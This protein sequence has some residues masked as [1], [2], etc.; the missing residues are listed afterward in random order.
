MALRRGWSRRSTPPACGTLILPVGMLMTH[1]TLYAALLAPLL[2]SGLLFLPRGEPHPVPSAASE[3]PPSRAEGA[4]Q[5]AAAHERYSP[6]F[7]HMRFATTAW[8]YDTGNQA[9][10]EHL[11]R[12]YDLLLAPLAVEQIHSLNPTGENL[13][14]TLLW[15]MHQP[16]ENADWYNEM[17]AW[18]AD[19]MR[20]LRDYR[21]EDAFLHTAQPRT[22][23][24]RMLTP[25]PN[26]DHYFQT[27]RWI[28]NPA[29]PGYRAYTIDRFND[30]LAHAPLTSIF[31]DEHYHPQIHWMRG[32][33]E[34]PTEAAFRAAMIDFYRT[35]RAGIG[36]HMIM[37]NTAQSHAWMFGEHG[38][39]LWALDMV[40]EAGGLHMEQMVNPVL[41][42]EW[43][44]L[45]W[46]QWQTTGAVIKP[47][48][49]VNREEYDAGHIHGPGPWTRGNHAT[50]GDRG[51]M[52]E[53]TVVYLTMPAE[54]AERWYFSPAPNLT[55]QQ[56]WYPPYERDIGK[57]VA[58]RYAI[59]EGTDP[60]GQTAMVWAREFTNALVLNRP[61][62]HDA[63]WFDDETA[64]P[65][66]LPPGPWYRVLD[67]N[68]LEATPSTS[69]SLRLAEGAIFVRG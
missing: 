64:M 49:N 4:P 26:D 46:E 29:D 23:A 15:H 65:V 32:S 30:L 67:D 14:Y 25:L 31:V 47:T 54:G 10:I 9:E 20:N 59:F 7:P 40:R 55:F 43:N 39:D 45:V 53:I 66:D 16:Q 56:S 61:R 38:E 24:T 22:E 69:I 27:P 21:F 57:P 36:G 48:A 35:V 63:G 52:W 2:L 50:P 34:L 19:R 41:P 42:Y 44:L 3:P 6:H 33:V 68:T 12:H 11:A 37:L 18:Y 1:R 8:L 5:A 60:R 17:R 13:P 58:P 28:M 62:W 51:K